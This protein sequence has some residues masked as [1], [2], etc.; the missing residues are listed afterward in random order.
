[1][2]RHSGATLLLWG[3]GVQEAEL[4]QVYWLCPAVLT[5]LSMMFAKDTLSNAEA[6]EMLGSM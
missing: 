5:N 2:K 6:V 1:M 3:E 4:G